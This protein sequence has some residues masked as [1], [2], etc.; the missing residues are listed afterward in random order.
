MDLTSPLAW[1]LVTTRSMKKKASHST[2]L[3]KKTELRIRRSRLIW[4]RNMNF[5]KILRERK[6]IREDDH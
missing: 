4:N 2:L 6:N 1:K 3:T 5:V